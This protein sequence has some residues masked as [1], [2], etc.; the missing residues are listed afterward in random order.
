[1]KEDT[2]I[3]GSAD[4]RIKRL[5]YDHGQ[6]EARLCVPNSLCRVANRPFTENA[7]LLYFALPP[8]NALDPNSLLALH[9]HHSEVKLIVVIK[10][11]VD[12]FQFHAFTWS[13][14]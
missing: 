2:I 12:I 9:K 6:K 8:I 7:H 10:K 14:F 11:V 1:M 4:N 3:S 5:Y 13:G